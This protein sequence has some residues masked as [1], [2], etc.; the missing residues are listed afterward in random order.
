MRLNYNRASQGN[1]GPPQ[2]SLAPAGGGRRNAAAWGCSIL[3]KGE[4]GMS[5]MTPRTPTFTTKGRSRT[6]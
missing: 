3:N 2:V 4:K 5:V 1:A 6:P